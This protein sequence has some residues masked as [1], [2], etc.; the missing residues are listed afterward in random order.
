[1]GR[2][3]LEGM[4]EEADRDV[5]LRWHL[6]SNHFPPVPLSMMDPCKAAIAAAEEEEWERRIELPEGCT[7]RGEDSAPASA[8]IR[9]HHLEGF[10][11]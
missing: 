8:I 5:A 6:Q 2:M 3:A 1:M 10:L 7:W 11:G 4:L 9:S